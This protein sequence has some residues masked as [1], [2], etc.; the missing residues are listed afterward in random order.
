MVETIPRERRCP[1]RFAKVTTPKEPGQCNHAHLVC[2][3]CG[4]IV[5]A[6]VPEAETM[7]PEGHAVAT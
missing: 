6:Q 2:R 5:E 4:A 3:D 7:K 1:L